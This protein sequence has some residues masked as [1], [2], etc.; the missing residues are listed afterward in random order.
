M[1]LYEGSITQFSDDVVQNRIADIVEKNYKLHYYKSPSEP[2]CRAWANSLNILNNSFTYS[3]LKDIQ[4][5]IEYE[6]PYSTRRIDVLIF[7]KNASN[8]DSVVLMELKQWSNDHVY[9][10]ENDG[11][12]IID[13]HGKREVP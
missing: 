10:S 7:G 2:E 4:I 1:R 12:V 13:F 11:N 3:G 5:I 6:L 8:K 9:D